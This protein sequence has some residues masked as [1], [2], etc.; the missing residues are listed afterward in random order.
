MTDGGVAN[1]LAATI[2][3]VN[4]DPKTGKGLI[5]YSATGSNQTQTADVGMA[6]V[7]VVETS[8]A[9]INMATSAVAIPDYQGE[10]SNGLTITWSTTSLAHQGVTDSTSSRTPEPANT[11]RHPRYQHVTFLAKSVRSHSPI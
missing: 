8:E 10:E 3:T 11:V 4:I 9:L 6:Y 2:T 5:S 7:P 1:V